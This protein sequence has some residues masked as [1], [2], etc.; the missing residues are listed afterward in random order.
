MGNRAADSFKHG[1][2]NAIDLLLGQ[3]HLG[4]IDLN[5]TNEFKEYRSLI[6]KYYKIVYR[7]DVNHLTIAMIWACRQ[8]IK[9]TD[10]DT[11]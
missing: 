6:I 8:E 7:L 3:P 10:H 2:L 5:F 4:K 11:Y 9:T 1:I